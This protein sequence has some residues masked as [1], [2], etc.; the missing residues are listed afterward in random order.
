MPKGIWAYNWVH[1]SSTFASYYR[2]INVSTTRK[3][4]LTR[5]QSTCLVMMKKYTAIRL[6]L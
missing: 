1:R 3:F 4:S 5:I 2:K 6:Y